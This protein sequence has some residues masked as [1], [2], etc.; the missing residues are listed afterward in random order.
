MEI[1]QEPNKINY[2]V[3]DKLSLVDGL[4]KSYSFEGD[5]LETISFADNRCVFYCIEK[6]EYVDENTI[7]DEIG[8]YTICIALSEGDGSNRCFWTINVTDSEIQKGDLDGDEDITIVD[9]RLLLQAYINGCGTDGWSEQDLELMDMDEDGI[10]NIIDVRLL[11]QI[12][13]NT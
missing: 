7:F 3:G 13:I 10:I 6:G 9:V 1:E 11:L 8:T 4:V 5:L 2:H 12:F